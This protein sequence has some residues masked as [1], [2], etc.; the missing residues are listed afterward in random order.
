MAPFKA[1]VNAICPGLVEEGNISIEERQDMA[2]QIPYGRPI[3]PD[4]IGKTV[5]WLIF[6]TA[7]KL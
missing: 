3:Y 5:K 7:R 2:N 4:E 6:L 1:R